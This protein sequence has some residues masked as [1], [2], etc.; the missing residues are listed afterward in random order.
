LGVMTLETELY[1]KD[2]NLIFVTGELT[3]GQRGL[4]DYYGC[5]ETPDDEDEVAIISAVDEDD[6]DVE[7]TEAQE[8]EAINNF[9]SEG[10]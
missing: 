8:D 4:R 1:D 6:N 3:R 10:Y 2:D 9:H 5:P 7:L